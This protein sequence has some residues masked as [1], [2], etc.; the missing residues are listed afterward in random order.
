ML[1]PALYLHNIQRISLLHF[2]SLKGRFTP[3]DYVRKR[4]PFVLFCLFKAVLAAYVSSYTY[5]G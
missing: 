5:G 2:I 4:R 3:T 1:T